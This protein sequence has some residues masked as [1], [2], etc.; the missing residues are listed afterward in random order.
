[1]VMAGEEQLFEN[2]A[3]ALPTKLSE[4]VGGGAALRLSSPV[5]FGKKFYKTILRPELHQRICVKANY[6]MNIKKYQTIG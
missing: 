6:C 4:Q 5:E 2:I 3:N 1:M